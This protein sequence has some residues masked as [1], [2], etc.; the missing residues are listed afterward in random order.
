MTILTKIVKGEDIY[1]KAAFGE[2]DFGTFS[3]FKIE[4]ENYYLFYPY[5]AV[6]LQRLGCELEFYETNTTLYRQFPVASK[7]TKVKKMKGMGPTIAQEEKEKFEDFLSKL[8]RM[9]RKK[10]LKKSAEEVRIKC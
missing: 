5:Q 8:E 3:A 9:L 2:V 6:A 7:E 4:D 1:S 10:W